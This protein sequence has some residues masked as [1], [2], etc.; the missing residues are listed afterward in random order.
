[1]RNRCPRRNGLD[2]RRISALSP[3][4]WERDSPTQVGSGEVGWGVVGASLRRQSG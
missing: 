2:Q 4:P 3:S 1:M